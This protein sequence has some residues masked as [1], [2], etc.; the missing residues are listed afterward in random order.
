MNTKKIVF[1]PS[2]TKKG[3]YGL[4]NFEEDLVFY[5]DNVK[6]ANNEKEDIKKME[7]EY[8]P[9][10]LIDKKKNISYFEFDNDIYNNTLYDSLY[11][12]DK[13]WNKR[14][15]WFNKLENG[16]KRNFKMLTFSESMSKKFFIDRLSLIKDSKKVSTNKNILD[17]VESDIRNIDDYVFRA[18]ISNG[19]LTDTNI[20]FNNKI[21]DTEC[22]GYNIVIG[23]LAILFVSIL[24]GGWIYPKYNYN[25]Y[26]FRKNK[27]VL[28]HKRLNRRQIDILKRV[29]SIVKSVEFDTFKKLVIFRLITPISMKI[30]DEDDRKSVDDLI[31]LIYISD[32]NTILKN[33]CNYFKN[34]F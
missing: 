9:V 4:C 32:Y 14:K 19:D 34:V 20:C 18:Y 13:Y 26:M 11:F 3:T 15:L 12:K 1:T 17:E 2:V 5:K 23:D 24:Y 21:C 6:Y 33:I 27:I 30:M 31:R 16:I 10:I 8:S 25:A 22:L 28:P 29:I 7:F